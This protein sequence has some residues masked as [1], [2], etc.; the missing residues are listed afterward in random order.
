EAGKWLGGNEPV[1]AL[2]VEGEVR[3]YPLQILIWHEI[4]NDEIGGV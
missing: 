2:E 1:I 3:A 4:V